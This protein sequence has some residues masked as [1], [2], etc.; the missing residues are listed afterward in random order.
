VI[1]VAGGTG[2]LGR[3]VVARLRSSGQQVR[4]L[5]RTAAR[6]AGLDA[7]I[8][9]GDV[10]DAATLP[11]AVNGCSAVVSAVHGFLGGR[12]AGPAAID[13]QGNANLMRAACEAGV[14][15]FVLVSVLDARADHPMS[16]HRAKYAAEQHL[17]A[18]GLSWTVLRPAAFTETWAGVIG[19]KLPAGGPALVFGRGTNPVNFVSAL[20]VAALAE[21]AITD[22]AL[23]GQAIDIP[24]PGNLTMVQFARLLGAARIRHVPRGALRLLATAAAPLTPAL[25]RQAAAALIMDT[26]SMAADSSALHGRFPDITWHQTPELTSQSRTPRPPGDTTGQSPHQGR[27]T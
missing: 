16:L 18:S 7:G 17:H 6:A 21:R 20:D 9:V 22:P 19:A 1:L 25:A 8:A 5:T 4:V 26:T 12:G 15:Q 27:N 14:G 3:E 13:A 2:T 24:G 23:R 11:G 10:R